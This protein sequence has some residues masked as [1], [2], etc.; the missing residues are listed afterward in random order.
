MSRTVSLSQ[1]RTDVRT[2]GDFGG[3]TVRHTDTQLNR[4]INNSIQM[5]R[6][7]ISDE[8]STHYLVSSS[9]TLGTGPTSPYPFYQLD[10]SALS[11]SLVR[12]YGIDVTFSG[13]NVV[14]L[15]YVPFAERAKY[16]S[17]SQGGTPVA[18]SHF[19][20]DQ[21]AILPASSEALPY[22]VWYLPKFTDLSADGDTF[23]GVAGWEEWVVWDV[24]SQLIAR[25]QFPQAFALAEVRRN[26]AWT[27]VPRGATKVTQAGGAHVGQD[28]FG[29]KLPHFL[30]GRN[31]PR[32]VSGGPV[33]PA[34]GSVTNVML[35]DMTGP[36]VKGVT[37][38]TTRPYDVQVA[39]LTTYLST[40]STLQRGLVPPPLSVGS[41][42]LRDD[43]TWASAAG[44][45][46]AAG[47]SGAVQF[48]G[49]AGAFG[50]ASGFAI[51]GSQPSMIARLDG[52]LRVTGGQVEVG[53]GTVKMSAS[54]IDAGNGSIVNVATLVTGR[55]SAQSFSDTVAGLT[56]ASGGGTTNFLRADGAWD[57]P[58][59]GAGGGG[60]TMLAA[61]GLGSIQYNGGSGFAGFTG[62]T[63]IGSSE[64]GAGIGFG[65]P[66]LL[67]SAVGGQIG[68]A[69]A[70]SM[71]ALTPSM[72]FQGVMTWTPPATVATGG[73]IGFGS[74]NQTF[75]GA[76]RAI[77]S[78]V[79]T[80]GTYQWR[81]GGGSGAKLTATG[82][83]VAD[84]HV[85][86]RSITV[87]SGIVNESLSVMASGT[88]K[89]NL[90]GN[91]TPSDVAVATLHAFAPTFTATNPGTVPGSGGGT[92]NY[93]RADGVW[94]APP[95]GS[96]TTPAGDT[97]F[98]QYRDAVGGFQGASG[99]TIVASGQ[100]LLFGHASGAPTTGDIRFGDRNVSAIVG[101]GRG[102]QTNQTLWFYGASG[103]S[104]G[105]LATGGVINH[106]RG[107]GSVQLHRI[108][109]APSGHVEITLGPSAT[110]HI[111]FGPS[112]I[113][114]RNYHLAAKG[115]TVTEKIANSELALMSTGTVKGNLSGDAAPS[116][117]PFATFMA[118]APT[119]TSTRMG[120]APASGG[121]TTNYLRADGVWDA[122]PGTAGSPGG[123]NT[124]LQF[125]NAGNFGGATGLNS[126]AN[127]QALGIG[128]P[129]FL[130]G[131]GDIR[132]ASGFNI[133]GNLPS[134]IAGVAARQNLFDWTG[135]GGSGTLKVG[136][137][138]GVLGTLRN[139]VATGGSFQW[140]VGGQTGMALNATGLDA[141][142]THVNAKSLSVGHINGLPFDFNALKRGIDIGNS[143]GMP[144]GLSLYL[145]RGVASGANRYIIPSGAVGTGT[146]ANPQF[147]TLNPTGGKGGGVIRIER[148]NAGGWPF[149][150]R[151]PTGTVLH[152]MPSGAK[153]WADFMFEKPSG[154]VFQLAG[155]ADMY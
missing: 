86:A 73:V 37:S 120:V 42:F 65:N 6:E 59:A 108:H 53:S 29:R 46:A 28:S 78:D 12:T 146:Q 31:P 104:G 127:G 80:G 51:I 99:V 55:I 7:R 66:T 16:G 122:P 22:V 101:L 62:I 94:D 50:T 130:P 137:A 23:D 103:L 8:G 11:P 85:A 123:G 14:S 88:V 111:Q 119:F 91:A 124:A 2:K 76:L 150:I 25:D 142:A 34:P 52:S 9:G 125:Y 155:H 151:T 138:S 63:V 57:V 30:G 13:G 48:Q 95:G 139:E 129:S 69:S 96:A 71:R 83:D 10:L 19:R 141:P 126:T 116:D 98:V 140:L 134:G 45:G 152:S 56:P 118:F 61:G 100:A 27:N 93:L 132:V 3:A 149:E 110:S 135:G 97:G 133:T 79:A 82:L 54:G 114:F 64:I 20:T 18:W 47:A 1:L 26:E 115:L 89:A 49:G 35:V 107:T 136:G 70:F 67:N 84:F 143:S 17:S 38:G 144:S 39:T 32:A 121:G 87:G 74:N 148:V 109:T 147:V 77:T 41:L 131:A 102:L 90:A 75:G 44:A 105:G 4:Y 92:T 15:D 117:V 112:G 81:F 40:F 43:G 72:G 60:P 128:V 24:V 21:V 113:D 145:P 154:A 68:M 5:F 106:G 33:V 36:T 153:S 58:P